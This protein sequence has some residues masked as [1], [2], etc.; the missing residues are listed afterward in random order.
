M[1]QLVISKDVTSTLIANGNNWPSYNVPFF[2]EIYEYA[3][4]EEAF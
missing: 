4:F 3:G 1:P 2:K